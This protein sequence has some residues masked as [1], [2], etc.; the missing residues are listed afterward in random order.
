[1]KRKDRKEL[2]PS[3]EQDS[4]QANEDSPKGDGEKIAV[5]LDK[6]F[7][8]YC[9][10]IIQ[11]N[12]WQQSGCQD[13]CLEDDTTLDDLL[14]ECVEEYVKEQLMTWI[15]FE[16]FQKVLA[17]KR[18]PSEDGDNGAE[19]NETV[20]DD[21]EFVFLGV[22]INTEWVKTFDKESVEELLRAYHAFGH[23]AVDV[24]SHENNKSYVLSQDIEECWNK[25][26][27]DDPVD[28]EALFNEKVRE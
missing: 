27:P 14:L 22:Q 2:S 11:F 6:D 7:L 4:E 3:G 13:N 23:R 20:T 9:K 1:M 18:N 5:L 28:D 12:R 8:E 21:N 19:D 26:N 25:K 17:E 24:M 10:W 16:A 15:S